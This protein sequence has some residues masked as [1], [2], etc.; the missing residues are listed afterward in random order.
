[1][2][3]A[4]A[5]RERERSENSEHHLKVVPMTKELKAKLN[6]KETK[7]ELP[8]ETKKEENSLPKQDNEDFH[9]VKKK[10]SPKLAVILITFVISLAVSIL[11]MVFTSSWINS[12]L[13]LVFS[14]ML[15]QAYLFIKKRLVVSMNIRK[16]EEVFPDF[17]QLMSSNL[18][19]GMTIDRALLLSSRKEFAPL[20]VEI[21][22]LGKDIVTGK[23]IEFAMKEM[24][25]RIDSEKIN[26]TVNL[27][28]SGIRSGGNI[29][30]LLEETATNM[31]EREFVEKRAASNV[32][33]YV[34]FVFFAIGIGSPTLFGLASIL[35]DVMTSL[36]SAIPATAT[37][38]NLPITLKAVPISSTFIIYFSLFFLLMTNVLGSFVLG[39]VN[40]GSEKE[41]FKFTIPL[42][43][44]SLGIFFGIRKLLSGYFTNFLG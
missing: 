43:L 44:M 8:Q 1:M 22:K 40:K 38:A 24:A 15:L 31:R 36:L 18:R 34:I 42:I 9:S 20:D 33:M 25:K 5:R 17:L 14:F 2:K 12:V 26:K 16:M 30:V 39:L 4:R 10:K 29:S 7:K 32:L 11:F 19:A 27:L 37:T 13:A 21:L 41:G 35:V 6:L 23:E 3:R 28:V